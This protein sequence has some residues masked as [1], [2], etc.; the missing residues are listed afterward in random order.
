MFKSCFI[1]YDRS[2]RKVNIFLIFLSKIKR[3]KFSLSICTWFYCA[4]TLHI[5]NMN[6]AIPK[7]TSQRFRSNQDFFG[8]L[9]LFLFVSIFVSNYKF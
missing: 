7:A 2:N 3:K 9:S 8:S 5:L 4:N 6:I 1:L